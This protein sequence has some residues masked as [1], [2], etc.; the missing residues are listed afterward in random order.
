M[1][2]GICR[3]PPCPPRFFAGQP[4][5]HVQ[6][7]ALLTTKCFQ[8]CLNPLAHRFVHFEKVLEEPTLTTWATLAAHLCLVVAGVR[9]ARISVARQPPARIDA[10]PACPT[11]TLRTAH[12]DDVCSSQLQCPRWEVVG[13]APPLHLLASGSLLPAHAAPTSPWASSPSALSTAL[14]SGLIS[15]PTSRTCCKSP[16]STPGLLWEANQTCLCA[17]SLLQVADAKCGGMGG[18]R[19]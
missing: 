16:G 12:P 10:A 13:S 1:Q 11:G 17:G 19:R 2:L 6:V 3:R 7:R 18:K 14:N 9:A 8:H 4:A 15:P 5:A